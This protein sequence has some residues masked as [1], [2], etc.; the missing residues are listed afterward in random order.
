MRY[1]MWVITG[2]SQFKMQS[3][4]PSPPYLWVTLPI[5]ISLHWDRLPEER[6]ANHKFVKGNEESYQNICNNTLMSL[7]RKAQTFS[8]ALRVQL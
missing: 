4:N 6:R 7:F 8:K 5:S 1:Q 2:D 3:L